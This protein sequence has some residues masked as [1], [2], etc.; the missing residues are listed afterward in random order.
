M[1]N[2]PTII[3]SYLDRR[4]K[5]RRSISPDPRRQPSDGGDHYI[6]NYDKD[7]YTPAP[8]YVGRPG[9]IRFPPPGFPVMPIGKYFANFLSTYKKIISK[10]FFLFL[11]Y[12]KIYRI[13]CW[14]KSSDFTS[15]CAYDANGLVRSKVR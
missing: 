9:D 8:R 2:S 15:W 14:T 3:F 10:E 13:Q 1:V 11:F 5:R 12:I 7:G 4:S 6:P